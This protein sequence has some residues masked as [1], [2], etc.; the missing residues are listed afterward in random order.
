VSD[1][2]GIQSPEW[3]KDLTVKLCGGRQAWI[4]TDNLCTAAP[5]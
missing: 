5:A 4:P 2:C 1:A 3:I